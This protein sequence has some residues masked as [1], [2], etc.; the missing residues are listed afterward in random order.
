MFQVG[1][2]VVHPGYGPGKVVDIERLSL[3]DRDKRY[4]KIRLLDQAETMVWIAVR[5]AEE[6]GVRC[7]VPRSR[8]SK[9]W[10]LLRGKPAD[11]P[12]KHQE[13]YEVVREKIENGDVLQIAE[14]LRDLRWKAYHVRSLTIE[15][16]RL[17]E[18]GMMLLAT[19][20]ALVQGSDTGTVESQISDVLGEN[21]D[22]REAMQ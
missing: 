20:V 1:E 11:L 16:K 3:S 4:Y 19:E 12:S 6:K 15:G 10:R 8:L 5:D 13:R 22:S 18:K 14:A 17:Y 21:I 9:V 2:A 7:P